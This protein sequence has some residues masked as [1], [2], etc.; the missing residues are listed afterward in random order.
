MSVFDRLKSRAKRP[1]FRVAGAATPTAAPTAPS[2][3]TEPPPR[4]IIP[5][6]Y[7]LAPRDD[8]RSDIGG[9]DP[10]AEPAMEA[11]Q[12]GDWLTVA[13]IMQHCGTDWERRTSVIARLGELAKDDDRWLTSWLTT[14]PNDPTANTIYANSLVGVAWGIRTGSQAEDVSRD[15]WQGFF[16]VLGQAPDHC[17]R[18]AA[19]APADPTP[20]IELL[21][22]ARGLQYDNDRFRELWREVISRAPDH[23][24]AH[25]SARGYWLP[26]WYGSTDL[27]DA[28]VDEATRNRPRGSLFTLVRL[29]A[30]FDEYEPKKRAD[31]AAY[32]RTPEPH[33]ILDEAAADLAAAPP[34]HP[35]YA[36]QRHMLAYF[37]TNAGRYAEAYDQF[38]AI[39]PYCGA[40]PWSLYGDPVGKFVGERA[41]AV[42]GW[43][44]AGRP[45]LP[46]R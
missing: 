2:P 42:I 7:G 29:R 35:H 23:L 43:E 18:A 20:W 41:R 22:V 19:N 33:R 38:A 34:S 17:L 39:G 10:V 26:R 6:D 45:P 36:S 13:G 46:Y 16:R 14:A 8:I 9:P 28:F 21:T 1:P 15:Q 11:A 25:L 31:Q 12:R 32:Y 24:G 27:H 30:M 3:Q 37:F 40:S 4:T 5:A 44:D